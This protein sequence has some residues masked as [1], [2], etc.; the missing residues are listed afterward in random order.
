MTCE[1]YPRQQNVMMVECP[2]EP[3]QR[4]YSLL[5]N[6]FS[7]SASPIAEPSGFK[8]RLPEILYNTSSAPG[9]KAADQVATTVNP[10]IAISPSFVTIIFSP[11]LSYDIKETEIIS[12]TVADPWFV[13]SGTVPN[14]FIVYF[15]ISSAPTVLIVYYQPITGQ[16]S[17]TVVSDSIKSA[18]SILSPDGINVTLDSRLG[19]FFV[20]H[21]FFDLKPSELD[22][23][24]NLQLTDLLLSMTPLFLQKQLNIECLNKLDP[25]GVCVTNAI[26]RLNTTNATALAADPP[27][28]IFFVAG[29]AFVVGLVVVDYLYM[30]NS[31]AALPG[32]NRPV[33][34]V[35]SK[36][37]AKVNVNLGE[38]D[39]Q[40]RPTTLRQ[41]Y[42]SHKKRGGLRGL[43]SDET[44]EDPFDFEKEQQALRERNV[45]NVGTIRHQQLQDQEQM[46]DV[47]RH[48]EAVEARRRLRGH[49]QPQRIVDDLMDTF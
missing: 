45:I 40:V 25:S 49:K 29:F 11:T 34:I 42:K 35:R 36:D 18:L 12:L 23:R 37:K 19:S 14:P 24:T 46:A 3:S 43:V 31:Q 44:R 8:V 17:P 32:G 47:V 20:L 10:F 22:S 39:Y 30:R 27:P 7:S 48:A 1:F 33:Q 2:I 21:L 13:R 28:T 16:Y 9:L 5:L 41:Y 38:K 6:G 4:L 15:T 26:G